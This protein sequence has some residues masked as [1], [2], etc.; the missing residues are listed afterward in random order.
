MKGFFA[1]I[2]IVATCLHTSH[3][4]AHSALSVSA[5]E[6]VA[7]AEASD[8]ARLTEVVGGRIAYAGNLAFAVGDETDADTILSLISGCSVANAIEP[9]EE[10]NGKTGVDYPRLLWICQEEMRPGSCFDAGY[11]GEMVEAGGVAFFTVRETTPRNWDRCPLNSG[12]QLIL[13][14]PKKDEQ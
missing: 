8:A 6:I 5:N 12:P 10:V 2:L 7:A 1:A 11:Y 4:R 13:V 3:V 9:F 14:S